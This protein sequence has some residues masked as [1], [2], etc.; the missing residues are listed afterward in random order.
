[1]SPE[2]GTVACST[3]GATTSS[4]PIDW[5]R[6]IDPRRGTVWVCPSCARRH[7]RSIEARLD[8]QWW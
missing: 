4:P 2:T 5:M 1:V 7:L 8:Q 6:E 3:C